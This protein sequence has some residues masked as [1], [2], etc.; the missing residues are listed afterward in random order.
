M[1]ENNSLFTQCS[2]FLRG[3]EGGPSLM[4]PGASALALGVYLPF[5][6]SPLALLTQA[7]FPGP[8]TAPI[9]AYG[10]EPEIFVCQGTS[11]SLISLLSLPQ[12][13]HSVSGMSF[14]GH[15]KSAGKRGQVSDC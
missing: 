1:K 15:L 10:P 7:E 2:H 5:S 13:G 3:S 9:L 4:L 11:K 12:R 6:R 14:M 8:S